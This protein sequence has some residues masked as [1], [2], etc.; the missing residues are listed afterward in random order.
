MY[1]IFQSFLLVNIEF[2]PNYD[3][4]NLII[5]MLFPNTGIFF[6]IDLF[7]HSILLVMFF[8]SLN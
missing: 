5:L 8:K 7:L 1:E 4:L 2:K 3:C 6:L